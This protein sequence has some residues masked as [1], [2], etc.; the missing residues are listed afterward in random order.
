MDQPWQYVLWSLGALLLGSVSVGDLVTRSAGVDIRTL[1][2]RNPG[3]ANIYREV[4][5]AYGIAVFLLDIVKGAA[6]T[7]PLLVLDVPMWARTLSMAALLAG[8]LFPVFWGFRGGT[9]MTVGMGSWTGVLPVGVLVAAPISLLAFGLTRNTG[10]NGA[11]FFLITLLVGG[12]VHQDATAVIAIVLAGL[13]L[14]VK[15]RLQYRRS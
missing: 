4:G 14:F 1:G 11:L 3:A 6:A 7:A 15:S 5:P 8:H 2:N 13:A 9:G 10:L 12:L